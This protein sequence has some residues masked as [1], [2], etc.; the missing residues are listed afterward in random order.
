M[1]GLPADTVRRK[2]KTKTVPNNGLNPIYEEEPFSFKVSISKCSFKALWLSSTLWE[3]FKQFFGVCRMIQMYLRSKDRFRVYRSKVRLLIFFGFHK[4]YR[5]DLL[6]FRNGSFV[7]CHF[8]LIPSTLEIW[9]DEVGQYGPLFHALWE[10][11]VRNSPNFS[12][13]VYLL[14]TKWP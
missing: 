10:I 1:Y 6:V 7:I 13:K 8:Y 11:M 3:V 9:R 5:P 14:F 12:L 4:F 2:Y